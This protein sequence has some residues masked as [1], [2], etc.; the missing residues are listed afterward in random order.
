MMTLRDQRLRDF[1]VPMSPAWLLNDLAEAKGLQNLYTR[2]S[3]QALKA[4]REMAL[5]QS[6]ESSNGIEVGTVA[7]EDRLRPLDLGGARPKYRSEHEIA[8]YR[9]ALS[10]IHTVANK[11]HITPDLLRRLHQLCHKG[12]G[13]VG[14]FKKTDNEIIGRGPGAKWRNKG[15]NAER[16]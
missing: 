1:A 15:N 13:D 7:G 4:L 9:R 16:V 2:L 14:E 6:V 8:G 10:R 5:V 11:L 3:P 12:R